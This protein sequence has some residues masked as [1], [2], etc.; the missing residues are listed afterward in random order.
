[1]LAIKNNSLLKGAKNALEDEFLSE[2]KRQILYNAVDNYIKLASPIT[3]LLVQQ[4]KLHD[5]STATIRNELNALEAMGYLK[6]LHTSSGRVPTTKGYRFY[7]NHTLESTDIQGADLGDI[8]S[9]MFART[10]SL[11]EIV[12]SISHVVSKTTHYPTVV[13]FDG[14]DNLVVKSIKVIYLL[15]S[16]LLILIET[17]AGAI[18]HT[19]S[20]SNKITP[21]DCENA[22]NAFTSIFAGKSMS[23]MTGNASDFSAKIKSAMSEYEEVFKLVLHAVDMYYNKT[24]SNVSSHGIVRLLDSKGIESAKRILTVLDDGDGVE[25]IVDKENNSQISV[26]IGKENDNEMLSDCSVIQAPLVLDGKRIAT[27]VVVG[28]ERIDYA[29]IASVLKFISDEVKNKTGR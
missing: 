10:S 12:E 9:E 5:L 21:Q 6:Q 23:F 3:S 15:T 22:S 17:N 14:F 26:K 11:S 2:R 25:S 16:Q 8:S 7:V 1:M 20:A 19:V 29:S 18:T 4:T 13:Y 27:A 28:P 24:K